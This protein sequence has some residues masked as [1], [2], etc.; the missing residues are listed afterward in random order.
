M[1]LSSRRGAAGVAGVALGCAL[2]VSGCSSSTSNS[3]D[4]A[5]T[6]EC[7]EAV[8]QP[9]V[10]DQADV[11]GRGNTM[12]IST[13]NCSNGWAVAQGTI[14]PKGE[15]A[16]FIFEAQG[17]TWVWQEPMAVCTKDPAKSSIPAD[18]YPTACPE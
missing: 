5:T 13:L 6:A 15:P 3:T 10:S 11:L 17:D 7:T 18:L 1:S 2:L 4:V 12:Q 14:E 16:T 8:L 9:A